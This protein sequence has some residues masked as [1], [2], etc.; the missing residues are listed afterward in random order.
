[1]FQIAP[2]YVDV[3]SYPTAAHYLVNLQEN[4]RVVEFQVTVFEKP[5][6]FAPVV[7]HSRTDGDSVR[8]SSGFVKKGLAP[9]LSILEH[10]ATVLVV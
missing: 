6:H 8:I 3:L 5:A 7:I 9:L 2:L 1:M 4:F 10:V